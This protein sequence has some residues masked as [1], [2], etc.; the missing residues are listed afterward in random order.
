MGYKQ[1]L[2]AESRINIGYVD[3]FL[4][5]DNIKKKS[6]IQFEKSWFCTVLETDTGKLVVYTKAIEITILK[7][8]CKLTL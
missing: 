2:F 5:K 1:I 6:N 3:F 7:E 8:L 4:K